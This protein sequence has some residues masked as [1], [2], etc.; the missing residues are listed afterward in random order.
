MK[1]F[2]HVTGT[3][4]CCLLLLVLTVLTGKIVDRTTGQPLTG[5]NV[6]AKGALKVVP[7]RS[8]DAGRFTLRVTPGRYTVTVNITACS[9]TL[10]YSC[11]AALP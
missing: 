7:A 9:T 4:K 2:P 1:T 8:D 6:N 10:D 3:A 11:A 5:V